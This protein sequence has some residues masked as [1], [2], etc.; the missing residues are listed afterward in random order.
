MFHRLPARL[1]FVADTIF[2][3]GTQKTFLI[4]FRNILCPQQMFPSWEQWATMCP[5][6]CVLVY[7]GL[8]MFYINVIAVFIGVTSRRGNGIIS[9]D[10]ALYWHVIFASC[11]CLFN[12][13]KKYL[14][15]DITAIQGF[16]GVWKVIRTQA[17]TFRTHFRSVRNQ[18]SGRFVPNKFW[19]KMFKTN[20][21]LF[22]L[23]Q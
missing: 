13:T 20:K 6:Q 4:L 8:K 18:P 19:H 15:A 3:T 5:Q 14:T 17:K 2:L 16:C 22:H 12:M 23:S 9:M 11:V 1:T 21:L 10:S 7:Q